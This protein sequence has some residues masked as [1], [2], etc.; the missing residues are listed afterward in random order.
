MS[1][2]DKMISEYKNQIIEKDRTLLSLRRQL[3]E[4]LGKNQELLTQNE[5]VVQEASTTKVKYEESLVII[6]QLQIQLKQLQ[7]AFDKA[8]SELESVRQSL[9]LEKEQSGYLLKDLNEAKALIAT[10]RDSSSSSSAQLLD[11][12]RDLENQVKDKDAKLKTGAN[13]YQQ[14]YNESEK[15]KFEKGVA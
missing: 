3:D 9:L 1:D 7:D 12:I 5:M 2:A 14:L 10:L 4:S 13:Q 11:K 8:T 15:H 6:H